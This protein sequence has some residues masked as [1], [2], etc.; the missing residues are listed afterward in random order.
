MIEIPRDQWGRPLIVP[1]DGGGKPVPY[2][3]VS[4]MAKVLDNQYNLNLWKQRMVAKGL[5]AD[6]GLL[7]R[8]RQMDVK[9]DRKA[10]DQICEDA[11]NLAGSQTRANLGTAMH[12]ITEDLDAGRP[13]AIM[14]PWQE[15]DLEAY[16]HATRNLQVLSMEQFVVNDEL[17]VAGTFDRV[18]QLP[19]GRRMIGDLKTGDSDPEF[20]MAVTTQ[21]AM[22]AGGS[23]YTVE[24]GR[25]FSLA[26]LGVSQ[27]EGLLV[28][29]PAG[30]GICNIYLLD[31][32][33][34][35]SA[36]RLAKLVFD[37]QK[38]ARSKSSRPERVEFEMNGDS[39]V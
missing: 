17:Q 2:T 27:T 33:K 37:F 25:T 30:Q 18:Y 7:A 36:A 35:A 38:D 26:S 13:L 28:H 22:Y 31:L 19:D 24:Q 11:M 3:R 29:L 4:T 10:F 34:G 16:R 1:A 14:E 15:A 5:S 23:L 21:T 39:D 32:T 20:A 9:A 12:A 8:V 6:P